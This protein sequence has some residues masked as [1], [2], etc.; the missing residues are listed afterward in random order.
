MLPPLLLPDS[1]SHHR[2]GWSGAC[3]LRSSS[4]KTLRR[5]A[6]GRGGETS[7]QEDRSRSMRP[8]YRTTI[9]LR[10]STLCSSCRLCQLYARRSAHREDAQSLTLP[11]AMV[12]PVAGISGY[13]AGAVGA[14]FLLLLRLFFFLLLCISEGCSRREA[15]GLHGEDPDPPGCQHPQ[16][17]QSPQRQLPLLAAGPLDH[18][19]RL[20]GLSEVP[21]IN[22]EHATSNTD[23]LS[24]SKLGFWSGFYSLR[25]QPRCLN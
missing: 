21:Q 19:R 25:T 4:Q 7:R 17:G 5:G 3:A 22:P 18:Q 1:G 20:A 23:P 15:A 9:G 10:S 11:A 16:S 2:E 24:A 12:L 13:F 6:G 8:R 14:L